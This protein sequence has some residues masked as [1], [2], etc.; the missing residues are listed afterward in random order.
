MTERVNV[1]EAI[2]GA[3]D[4]LAADNRR[5][6]DQ[7][8]VFS[9][10][11]MASPGA[12]K[13]SL[14]ERT[15]AALARSV[16]V[17]VIDGDIATSLDADRAAAAGAEAIQVNTGGECH[18]DAVMIQ[19]ALQRLS[20]DSLDL[21]IVENVGNLVCPASFALGTHKNVLIASVPEGADKPHKYPGM[22]RG[23]QALVLNK[24]DLLPYVEFDQAFFQQGVEALNPGV[25]TFPLSC[26]T[27]EGLTAW[28][29]WIEAEVRQFRQAHPRKGALQQP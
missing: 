6:L 21:L 4:R 17:G 7:A 26:R 19:P 23:I 15:L 29:A 20:L 28:L 13:T 2:L 11:L 10:N 5:M 12:G 8:G 27:G 14:I 24:I 22:Y 16:R 25:V 3:N 18:L 9:L 1:G